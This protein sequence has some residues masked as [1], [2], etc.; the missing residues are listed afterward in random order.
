MN[1]ERQEPRM[2]M[3]VDAHSQHCSHA[4]SFAIHRIRWVQQAPSSDTYLHGAMR[5]AYIDS[6]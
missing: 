6:T 4:M 5:Q 1:I 2:A 3:A